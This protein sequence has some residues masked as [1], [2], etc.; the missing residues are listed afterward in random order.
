[1]TFFQMIR[2][3]AA[4]LLLS[5]GLSS[6][7]SAAM[8][9]ITITNTQGSDGLY[10]TPLLS[11]LHDGTFDPFDSGSAASGAVELLAEEGDASGVLGDA[12]AAGAAA[13]V[14]TAPGGF[15]GAPVIDPG[16]TASIRLDVNPASQRFVSFMA[17][18]IPSNDIFIGNDNSMAYEVF[19]AL[20]Q[21]TGLGPISIYTDDA[22]DAGTEVNNG[23][24]APF[25]MA[26]G[27]ATDVDGL[28]TPASDRLFFLAGQETAAG[29]TVS[30]P[31]GRNLL[32]TIEVSQVPLPAGFPLLLVGLGAFAYLR[33]SRA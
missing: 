3:S 28:I 21:F 33:R 32:A 2:R 23:L 25:N 14:I 30:L 8:V 26:G 27:V 15:A 5:A 6:G 31:S 17:M 19:D 12:L 16:E 13:G 11:V 9:D 20:G 7:A 4:G 18:V 22:W 24:G 10:L 29:S 1:M